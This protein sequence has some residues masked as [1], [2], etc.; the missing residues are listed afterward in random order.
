MFTRFP[1]D[2]AGNAKQK[3]IIICNFH[4]NGRKIDAV[5]LCG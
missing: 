4:N 1:Q 2:G 5:L 3:V